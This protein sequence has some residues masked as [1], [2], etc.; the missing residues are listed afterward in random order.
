MEP[1][2][3]L[4]R[5]PDALPSALSPLLV[6]DSPQGDCLP[7]KGHRPSQQS[8]VHVSTV[9]EHN[10]I[11]GDS[12]TPRRAS[13]P[14]AVH[15]NVPILPTVQRARDAHRKYYTATY[16]AVCTALLSFS[17]FPHVAHRS[18]SFAHSFDLVRD[19]PIPRSIAPAAPQPTRARTVCA[20]LLPLSFAT[21]T[22]Q[23]PSA[24]PVTE[25]T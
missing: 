6:P 2:G 19:A 14:G 21:A 8:E 20:G 3:S 16:D 7:V 9:R 13:Y 15:T 23:A 1:V 10:M 22:A 11:R 24:N 5:S 12:G 17:S 4:G 25:A 18:V